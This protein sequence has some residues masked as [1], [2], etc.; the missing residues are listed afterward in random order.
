MD[1]LLVDDSTTMLLRLRRL[2]ETEHGVVVTACSD[3]LAALVEARTCAFDLVLVDQHM[4]E[5]D[6]I[7]FIREIRAIPHYAQAP[8]AMVT[9][10]ACDT[11]ETQRAGGGRHRLP[12]QAGQRR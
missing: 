2:L 7:A 12:R 1:V 5:M 11:V 4:P 10:D 8:V 6:G 9:S 3:P